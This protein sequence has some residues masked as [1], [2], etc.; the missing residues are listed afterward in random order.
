MGARKMK[1]QMVVLVLALVAVSLPV[2]ATARTPEG[3]DDQGNTRYLVVSVNGETP[4]EGLL[5]LSLSL[6]D[7]VT[8]T[9]RVYSEPSHTLIFAGIDDTFAETEEGAAW[10]LAHAQ[11]EQALAFVRG[12][13]PSA[14]PNVTLLAPPVEDDRVTVW[15]NG[16]LNDGM[17]GER[18][19]ADAFLA[20]QERQPPHFGFEIYVNARGAYE[21]CC[22]SIA[23]SLMCVTCPSHRFTCCVTPNC[24][25][26]ACGFI[27]DL[28]VDCPW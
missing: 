16:D 7:M 25:R 15:V 5:S 3:G 24:C 8:K 2:T 26:I 27:H 21:S 13:L 18:L 1:K 6:G 22:S 14:Q 28:C 10:K 23:C 17:E 4:R 12:S 9:V 11:G 20:W 19:I